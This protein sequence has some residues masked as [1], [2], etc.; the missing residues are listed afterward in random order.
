MPSLMPPVPADLRLVVTDLDGT[1]LDDAKRIP[2]DLWPLLD[3]LGRRDIVFSPASGRQ[4]ATLLH[5]FGEA[6]PGLIVIAENGAVVARQGE[7]LRTQPLAPDTAK[8]V[9]ARARALHSDGADL[10]VVLCSPEIAYVE[11][12]DERFLEQ[13]RPY[14]YANTVVDDLGA[15]DAEFV[16]VAVY[17]FAGI[18]DTTAPAVE[19]LSLDAEVVVSGQ[20]WLDVMTR[21]VDKS[22]AVRAVQQRLG[23]SPAQ[24]MVFGDYLND[25]GMLDTADWSYAVANAHQKILDAA[26]YVAPSNNDNGVVRTVRAALETGS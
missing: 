8:A 24:T 5:Q 13:I 18:E 4:A 1:L 26:R 12:S 19:A 6:V 16:K 9:L 20:H 21:G 2:D 3:E 7:I 23:V 14:Y 25:L 17:D 11:R 22:Q 10:G 15:V